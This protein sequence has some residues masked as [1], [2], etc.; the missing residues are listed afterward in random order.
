MKFLG[1]NDDEEEIW[2]LVRNIRDPEYPYTLGQL[3]VVS[4]NSM[5]MDSL[6]S[7]AGRDIS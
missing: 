7:Q 1:L 3:R 4:P 6:F 5:L 2:L